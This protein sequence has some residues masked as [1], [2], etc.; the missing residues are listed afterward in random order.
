MVLEQRS[1]A[2]VLY[3]ARR[4]N[5]IKNDFDRGLVPQNRIPGG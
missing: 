1:A 2:A 5:W 4:A 3:Y